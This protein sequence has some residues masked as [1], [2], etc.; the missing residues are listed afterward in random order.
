MTTY[1]RFLTAALLVAVLSSTA[2]S[3][4]RFAARTGAKCQSCHINP[5]G[6]KMRQAF[7]VRYGREELPVLFG[8]VTV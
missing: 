4:P 3:L 7:G 5:S 2:L 8:R 1:S 6:G